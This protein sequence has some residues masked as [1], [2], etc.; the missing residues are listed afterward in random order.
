MPL[1]LVNSRTRFG[2]VARSL[3]WLTALLILT[4]I[5]LGLYANSLPHDTSDALA[6]KAQMFS[7]HKTLGVAAFFVALVRILWALTQPRPVPL[8]PDRRVETAVADLVHWILYISLLAVPLSGW[9]HHAATTGFAPILWPFGQNL[10]LVPKIPAV[11]HVAATAHWLF[12]KLLIAAI[13]LHI[14]GALKHHL[15]DRDATLRR[16]ISGV[17]A[18]G[19]P[20]APRHGAAPMLAA[21]AIY[22]AGSGLAFA[23]TRA[24]PEPIET[25][26]PAV[27]TGNWQ[28]TEGTL[29][30]GVRQIGADVQGSFATWS[31]DITFD[32]TTGMGH[33]TVFI[34]IASLTLGSVGDQA[35]GAEFLDAAT[36]PTA[37]FTAAIRPEGSTFIAEGTLALRGMSQPLAMPFSLTIEGDTALMEGSTSIDRRTFGIGAKYPDEATV[38]FAAD[39]TVGL[40][41]KRT[42]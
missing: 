9:V 25:A 13:L 29:S 14:A 7:L 10:P 30:L 19:I 28:V 26:T 32:D 41:A 17:V 31:A 2:T 16:M 33:V 12:T 20:Q 23:L 36:H 11:E 42:N 40:T 3:H 5:P 35:K 8:H 39:V 34:D 4:A 21:L 6:A 37:T 27:T 1:P 22:A 18:P 38:G 15:I 24:E